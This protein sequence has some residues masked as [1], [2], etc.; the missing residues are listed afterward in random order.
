MAAAQP[1]SG[2][3]SVPPVQARP[4]LDLAPFRGVR[5]AARDGADLARLTC[6]PYDVIDRRQR[7]ELEAADPHNVVRL[8]LPRED[9]SGP[10]PGFQGA[11]R[12]LRSWLAGGV[13]A[14]DPHPALYVYEMRAGP[15]SVRGLI[16]ALGLQPAR[17]G[18]VLPHEDTM[19]GPVRHRRELI[20]ATRA[21]LE[22]IYL[23]ADGP[24][25]AAA[26]AAAGADR[27]RPLAEFRAADGSEHRMWSISDTTELVRITEDLHARHA[28]IADGHHRYAAYLQH[29]QDRRAHGAGAGPWDRGLA[30]LV[31]RDAFG[32]QVQVFHRVV[33]GLSLDDAVPPASNGFRLVELAGGGG[34]AAHRLAEAGRS[35]TAFVLTDGERWY[36]LTDPHPSLLSRSI[37]PGHSAAWRALDVV[38]LHHALLAATWGVPVDEQTVRYVADLDAA[39]ELARERAGIA[40]LMNPTPLQTVLTVAAAGERMP[41]KST[42]F[43]PKPRTGLVLRTY[44]VAAPDSTDRHGSAGAA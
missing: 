32:A 10:G 40:V 16:G 17:S 20:A 19:P 23:V 2:Q 26:A 9:G 38:V 29:Q 18:V 6:P 31:D 21:N 22:P 37:P 34:E 24:P 12:A 39:V 44:D 27:H 11:A 36:L 33:A 25:G 41:Q 5:Y 30:L 14:V 35:G 3:T 7:S 1:T 43:T 8:I 4:G 28:L 15:T 13:L 42:L